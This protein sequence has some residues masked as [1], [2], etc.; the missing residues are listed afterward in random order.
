LPHNTSWNPI[1][2]T[3]ILILRP[4]LLT[5][6]QKHNYG[7]S[8]AN[9]A[10]HLR[11]FLPAA[12]AA[13]ASSVLLVSGGGPKRAFDTVAALRL[14]ASE[15]RQPAQPAAAGEAE[16]AGGGT[17][18]RS[19]KRPRAGAAAAP[20]PA[21][22]DRQPQQQPQPLQ[23][24]QQQQQH[25]HQQRG[26]WPR[27]HVAF[28]PHHPDERERAA[29]E[30]ALRAKLASGLV[31]GVY[32][33]VRRRARRRSPSPLFPSGA[34][35]CVAAAP[36]PGEP[37]ARTPLEPVNS[38]AG[39][40]PCPQRAPPSTC[41]LAARPSAR[42]RARPG[43]Q[44]GTDVRRLEEGLSLLR[45]LERE[46]REQHSESRGRQQQQQPPAGP[47]AP[48]PAPLEVHGSVLL[49]SAALLARLRFRPW[50][51]VHL[52]AGYLS[53]VEGA[54]EAT[55]K[56]LAA[57][58]AHGVVPI[59]ESEL[60]RC[61]FFGGGGRWAAGQQRGV[62]ACSAGPLCPF[63]AGSP[64]L[65]SFLVK[66]AGGPTAPCS[67]NP[68]PGLGA[69]PPSLC[70]PSP[71]HPWPAAPWTPQ[72]RGPPLC[73][74]AAVRCVRRRRPRAGSRGGRPGRRRRARPGGGR[75]RR[76]RAWRPGEP[77]PPARAG[78]GPGRGSVTR[79]PLVGRSS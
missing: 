58:A 21:D 46:Q 67:V 33:Q 54:T 63:A 60:R 79:M 35:A 32:L 61:A 76:R 56:L 73:Y 72:A 23:Q 62:P 11:A 55:R 20:G 71:T 10:A 42:V 59:V 14:L 36:M 2:R 19:R 31:A 6:S 4:C 37:Q 45:R 53:G 74:G 78:R 28:N 65:I 47:P 57:Y 8:A 44:V 25:Q 29:E 3:H 43:P 9:A 77:R 66:T 26:Q 48:P 75:R 69:S 1:A 22:G 30:A 17:R 38:G 64:R 34:R 18:G 16:G 50:A 41:P 13:G 51:G 5:A 27:L 39:A 12:A 52:S 68:K 7:G 24:Q 40:S 70:T 15:A 49:P